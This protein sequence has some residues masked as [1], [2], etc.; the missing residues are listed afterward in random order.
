MNYLTKKNFITSGCVI[1]SALLL[2]FVTNTFI[3]PAGLL[4]GGFMGIAILVN[5][6]GSLFHLN[7]PISVVLSLIN[8]PVAA[9]CAKQI[10]RRF[11][12]F[13]IL[14]VLLTSLFIQILPS[15]PVFDDDILNIVFGG[16]LNGLA[17]A[18]A[19]RGN[20]STGGT[21]FIALYVANRTGKEIWMQVFV[22]NCVLLLVFGYLFGFEKAG[23]SILFQF[24]STRTISTFHSRYKRISLEI[25]TQKPDEV[26]DAYLA[27]FRHGITTIH[28]QGGYSHQDTSLLIAIISSYE[29]SEAVDA[30]RKADP[31]ILIN[32]TKSEQFIGKFYQDAM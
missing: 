32:V 12:F 23:Y 18:I 11:V 14:Q 3:Q 21:D 27:H 1:A 6:I 26:L 28:A 13:S 7:I 29:L 30:L 5:R 22:F 2:A 19:L 16:V 4:S 20:A 17:I 15:I 24:C 9:F 25:F 8:V 31:A 10:S